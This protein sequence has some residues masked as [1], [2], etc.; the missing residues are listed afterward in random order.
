MYGGGSC[1]RRK[2]QSDKFTVSSEYSTTGLCRRITN[3]PRLS[4]KAATNTAVPIMF[5]SIT[6]SNTPPR[7]NC[8][9]LHAT[10]QVRHTSHKMRHQAGS[11]FPITSQCR[12]ISGPY[13]VRYCPT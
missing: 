3:I 11:H 10:D 4:R 5:V 8:S 2:R 13:Y 9:A 7:L 12:Q 6:L 1:D